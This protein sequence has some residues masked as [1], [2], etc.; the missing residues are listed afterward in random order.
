MRSSSLETIMTVNIVQSSLKNR[1]LRALPEQIFRQLQ[2]ALAPVNLPV[3]HVLVAPDEPT[4]AVVFIESGVGSIVASSAEA[5]SS[6]VGHVGREGMSGTHLLMM[7]DRTP[8]KIFMQVA[9]EGWTLPAA[10]FTQLAERYPPL[11]TLLLR[12]AHTVH[13]QLAQS[14]LANSR[15]SMHQRLARWILMSHDRVDGDD[16]P[17]THEFLSLMLGTRRSGITDHIHM[18]EGK[19]AIRA[20]RGNIQVLDRA[21][22]IRIAGGCYGLPEREYERLISMPL[23]LTA[24]LD[25]RSPAA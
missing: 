18:L 16:I 19:H 2:P 22:L 6:E 20:K 13:I 1:L 5:Q 25:G 3:H 9:G 23:T 8:N 14:V 7:T 12:Y 10:S 17:L 4:E 24:V 11:R 15:Y 21:E